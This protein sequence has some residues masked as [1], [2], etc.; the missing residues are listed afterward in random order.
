MEKISYKD[1]LDFLAS[2]MNEIDF[3]GCDKTS[4]IS[5]KEYLNELKKQK[6]TYDKLISEALKSIQ[7]KNKWVKEVVP[8]YDGIMD[9]VKIRGK[10]DPT[11][12]VGI[13][14][15]LAKKFGKNPNDYI[16]TGGMIITPFHNL[17]FR[18][19]IKVLENSQEEIREIDTIAQNLNFI[20][21]EITT[22][23]GKFVINSSCYNTCDIECFNWPIIKIILSTGE[24]QR[25]EPYMSS[26]LF[27]KKEGVYPKPLTLDDMEKLV[28]KLY[29]K[30]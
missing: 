16:L 24:L 25:V 19:R 29:I 2:D 9:G 15:E 8:R 18:N 1:F 22:I 3:F 30:H 7:K 13:Y 11:L 28:K 4:L 17:K 20:K 5:L 23:S 27:Y 12:G 10:N 14:P 21:E 26:E 6:E